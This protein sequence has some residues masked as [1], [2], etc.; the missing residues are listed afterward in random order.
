MRPDAAARDVAEA[1]GT[2]LHVARASYREISL[3]TPDRT[4]CPVDLSDNTNLW[5]IPPAVASAIRDATISSFTRYPNVYAQDVKV[6]LGA[7]LGIE[8]AC[9]VTGCGSDDVLDSA[10]R[11]FGEPGQRIAHPDPSFQMVPLF[12]RMN[13]LIPV[14]FPLTATFDIDPSQVLAT[15][16]RIIYLCSPNNPTGA[17]FSRD[18]IEAVLDGARGIVVLDEAYAEYAG[19]SAVDLI[20]RSDRLLI[21]RTLSKAFGLAGLR[22]GYA[23]GA[24]A[25]VAEVEK[26]RGPYKVNAVAE[27]AA[28]AAL[29]E[30]R[31]W[32]D[33]KIA[34]AIGNRERL[35]HRLRCM[36][37]Q[38]LPS[39]ANFLLVPVRDATTLNDL[40]RQRGVAVRPFSALPGIGDALRISLGPWAMVEEALKSLADV[41]SL[42]TPS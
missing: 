41:L 34:E 26:S 18:A 24:P 30:G 13:G 3:Y 33:A 29:G 35:A 4:P 10:V 12:A 14:G 23:A 20:G 38:P 21:V 27:R 22:L 8:A 32:V 31:S 17:A 25:L 16:A 2:P 36:G 40:L 1:A 5:G 19:I 9:I 6:A 15:D 39:S 7:Y 37:L 28:L 42:K 11:A